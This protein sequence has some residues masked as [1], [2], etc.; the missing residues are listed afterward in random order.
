MD[1]FI[2][3]NLSKGDV[4]PPTA[5]NTIYIFNPHYG[6][7]AYTYHWASESYIQIPI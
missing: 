4:M 6:P 1:P 2:I 3:A 5:F 7:P